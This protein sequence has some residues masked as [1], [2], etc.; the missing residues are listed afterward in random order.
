LIFLL[1][2]LTETESSWILFWEW[3]GIFLFLTDTISGDN[4]QKKE[5]EYYDHHG[6]TEP[7]SWYLGE[8]MWQNIGVSEI[9]ENESSIKDNHAPECQCE[10]NFHRAL[11]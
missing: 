2:S 7:D 3:L 11:L 8:K 10:E 6:L 1:R 5:T 9:V 4:E